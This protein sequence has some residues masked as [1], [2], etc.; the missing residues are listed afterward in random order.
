MNKKSLIKQI[1]QKIKDRLDAKNRPTINIIF[2]GEPLPERNGL[3]IILDKH[4]P[5]H[6]PELELK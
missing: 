2:N 3:T 5:E 6:E 1:K 4:E